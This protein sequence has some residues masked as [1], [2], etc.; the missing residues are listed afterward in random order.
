M[1]RRL[2][3][4]LA[5]LSLLLAATA[6]V[7]WV[8]SYP[9]LRPRFVDLSWPLGPAGVAHEAGMM[10]FWAG[11]LGG[12]R[13]RTA[14]GV[15]QW[16]VP[17]LFFF[18]HVAD[19]RSSVT[20]GIPHALV[21]PAFLVLPAVMLRRHLRERRSH[22]RLVAGLCPSCGYDLRATPGRC[23]E[24]GPVTEDALSAAA[25]PAASIAPRR[26]L[27][28]CL[29][30][31]VRYVARRV[32]RV[33]ALTAIVLFVIPLVQLVVGPVYGIYPEGDAKYAWGLSG[34]MLY[35]S[36]TQHFPHA[37]Q[38]PGETAIA[39]TG[40]VLGQRS[41]VIGAWSHVYREVYYSAVP[42]DVYE[43]QNLS[44]YRRAIDGDQRFVHVDLWVCAAILALPSAL[45]PLN[46][47]RRYVVHG[48]P[49]FPPRRKVILPAPH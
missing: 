3:N 43:A 31:R 45:G 21:L 17:G 15:T 41:F 32:A 22:R 26:R 48:E 7:V 12:A 38:V 6:A 49:I 44:R 47:V 25:T 4:V 42:E 11:D 37:P 14:A 36:R 13:P 2:L 20:I 30:P 5:V 40:H 33:S 35:V 34:P 23:P 8:I 10:F 29:P 16:R 46:R 9:P 19:P 18:R 39:S 28:D 27:S 24:C 1:A